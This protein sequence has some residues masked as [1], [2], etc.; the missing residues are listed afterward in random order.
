MKT[1]ISLFLK[2]IDFYSLLRRFNILFIFSLL[3]APKAHGAHLIGAEL[4]YECTGGSNYTIELAVYRDCYCDNCADLDDPAYITIFNNANLPV[5]NLS[6][7]LITSQ[8]E[9]LD[10]NTDNICVSSI[11]DVCVERYIYSASAN[12][13]DIPGGYNIVWQRCCRNNTINNIIDPGGTGNTYLAHIPGSEQMT[14]CNSSPSFNN[15]P[16]IV[17]CANYPLVFDHSATDIDGDSLVYSLCDP[18]TGASPAEPYPTVASPPPYNNISWLNPF[19]TNNQLGGNPSLAINSETGLL[20]GTPLNIGQYVVGICVQEFRD[21]VLL[22]T[23]LRD[24]QF[25]VTDCVVVQAQI[26]SDDIAPTGEFIINECGAYQVDFINTSLGA[27]NYWWDF[28]DS[29][30]PNDESTDINPTYTYPGPGQYIVTLVAEP[31]VS[32]TDTAFIELNLYPFLIPNMDANA[33]C[34]SQPV[35]FTDQSVSDFGVIDSWLWDFG[36]GAISGDQNPTYLYGSAGSYTVS[37]TITTDLGCEETV[38]ENIDISP[39]PVPSISNTLLCIDQ[40]PIQFSD[41]SVI[42]SGNIVSWAWDFGDTNTSTLQNPSHTYAATGDYTVELIVTSDQG[43]V[44]IY[45]FDFTIYPITVADAGPDQIVCLGDIVQLSA[46]GGAVYEWD[47]GSELISDENISNP[48]YIA[49]SA[50]STFTVEVSD[51]NGCGDTDQVMITA[52]ALPTADTGA[53]ITI[54]LGESTI[55]NATAADLNNDPNNV[56]ILWTPN[57]N[58]SGATTTNP[59]VA[60]TQTTTYV[61]TVTDLGTA[62]IEVD[63]IVVNVLQPIIPQIIDDLTICEGDEV[64]LTAEGGDYYEWTPSIGLS[65]SEIADPIASPTS[66]TTYN[67]NISNDCFDADASVTVEVLPLPFV[68]AGEPGLINIGETLTLQGQSEYGFS[69]SPL[70]GILSS[71]MDATPLVQPLS[72]TTYYLTVISPNGC[73]AEDSTFVEVTNNIFLLL[74]NAFSPNG[75]G[76][77]DIL[78]MNHAG[79]KELYRFSIWNRWG[80]LVF[81]TTDMSRGWDGLYNGKEQP[82]SAFAYAIDALSWEEINIIEKGNITLIR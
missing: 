41:A 27:D 17:I 32:C 12:L 66:T 58:I 53:D 52:L 56:D 45:E 38:T 39:S 78:Y 49:T 19:G 16:P 72:S 62:C 74:P 50:N 1:Y 64:Q 10:P 47:T 79:I 4:T 48:T 5:E 65:D 20:T 71:P 70:E 46:S 14:P 54:C 6:I 33:D 81:T 76:V 43:C 3:L 69:W 21:G 34:S 59:E 80:E 7:D 11:P 26:E 36:D 24:F 73:I 13:P 63:S 42:S 29:A 2:L 60:P 35:I 40:Q 15:F 31:G 61:M 30:N 77:N 82:I 28:G 22:S 25:N 44:S 51:P 18:Y 75:D 67:V 9:N 8:I 23:N 55:I 57:I 37:L 68:D